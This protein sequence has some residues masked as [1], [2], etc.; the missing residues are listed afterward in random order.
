MFLQTLVAL[1]GRRLHEGVLRKVMRSPCAG[2]LAGAFLFTSNHPLVAADEGSAAAKVTP[3][4]ERGLGFLARS[5]HEDGS[6]GGKEQRGTIGV[7]SL[8]GL[9]RLAE[10]AQARPLRRIAEFLA[11]SHQTGS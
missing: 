5:Q 1:H 2:L 10:R 11:S 8:A 6:L 4:I 9:A 3:A 7:T